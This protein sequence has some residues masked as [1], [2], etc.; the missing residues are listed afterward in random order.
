MWS[1]GSVMMSVTTNKKLSRLHCTARGF[2]EMI[3]VQ[4]LKSSFGHRE[5]E[6]NV[7]EK[8]VNRCACSLLHLPE[9]H[10]GYLSWVELL[11]LSH[12]L[13]LDHRLVTRTREHLE[14]HSFMSACTTVSATFRSVSRVASNT[15][16]L[17]WSSPAT[18]SRSW[19]SRRLSKVAASPLI[20]EIIW[21]MTIFSFDLHLHRV[22]SDQRLTA[23]EPLRTV[24]CVLW[25]P[26]RFSQPPRLVML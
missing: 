25:I 15:V 10:G 22:Q 21:V 5:S 1:I 14:G 6:S 7:V 2:F 26:R 17:F 11:L 16:P 23:D 19:R 3:H 4:L 18:R 20:A 12:G 13:H 9:D 8:R 24:R